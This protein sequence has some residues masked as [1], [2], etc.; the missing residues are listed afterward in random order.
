MTEAGA[1][2]CAPPLLT[3]TTRTGIRLQLS[4][5]QESPTPSLS[6]SGCVRRSC[7]NKGNV[8]AK[9]QALANIDA[10]WHEI[11]QAGI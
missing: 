9:R 7:L 3:V 4:D 6:L 8:S 2:D 1:L 11:W 5:G 10:I